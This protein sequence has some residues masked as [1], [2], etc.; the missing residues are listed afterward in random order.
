MEIIG[1]SDT[2]EARHR[3]DNND[4]LAA[5]E[6]S[7]S[8]GET[9]LVDLVVD[10]EIFLDVFVGRGYIGFG[11]IIVVV[12]YEVF[13]GIVGEKLLHLAIELCGEGLVVAQKQRRPVDLRDYIGHGER[14]PRTGHTEKC[15]RRH[16]V[17]DTL[18]ELTDC[19]RLIACRRIL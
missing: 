4:V 16:T 14:L 5:G 7:G 13:D 9:E 1:I 18:Y 12:A 6:K 10:H 19:L 11:L 15:L 8:G 2:I 3:R 17:V